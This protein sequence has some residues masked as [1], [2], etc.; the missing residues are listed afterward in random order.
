MWCFG[1]NEWLRSVRVFRF[2]II[3]IN[4]IKYMLPRA[5][6]RPKKIEV[7]DYLLVVYDVTKKA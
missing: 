1:F 2:V 4:L 6:M 7:V 3:S 5:I